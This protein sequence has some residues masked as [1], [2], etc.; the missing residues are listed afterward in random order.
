MKLDELHSS[1]S[2]SVRNLI[3]QNKVIKPPNFKLPIILN[4][5][6]KIFCITNTISPFHYLRSCKL[7]SEH[8]H[9]WFY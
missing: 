4:L 3:L 9:C 5:E 7:N 8:I 6:I 2:L 1:K